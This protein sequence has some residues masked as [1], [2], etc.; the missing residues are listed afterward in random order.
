[1]KKYNKHDHGQALV[2]LLIFVMMGL[3]IA[4][5]ASFIIASNSLASTN[6][7]EGM[8]ARQMADSGVET[9]YIAILRNNSSYLGE[10]I[11]DLNG[12]SV[13]VSVTWAG[14]TATVNSV[15]TN[16]KF[17]KEVESVVTYDNNGLTKVSWKEA[18]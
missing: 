17:I 16:G 11:T 18:N 4:V 6:V 15:A 5:A 9:A 8:L 13:V 1:M 10:T 7:Q 3:A 14:S 2:T 12:G